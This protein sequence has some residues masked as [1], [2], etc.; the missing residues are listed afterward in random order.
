MDTK[1]C[2][3]CGKLFELERDKNNK[4]KQR[5]TCSNKCAKELNKIN[6][7]KQYSN[8][9]KQR[10]NNFIN[11]FNVKF[12]ERFEYVS[13]YVNCESIITCRCLMCGNIKTVG[14][15]CV[16]KNNTTVIVCENCKQIN[17][18]DKEEEKRLIHEENI[19]K[20]NEQRIVRA[21]ERWTKRLI[22][23]VKHCSQCGKLINN[24]ERDMRII[25][26]IFNEMEIRNITISELAA[27]LGVSKT[28]IYRWR[29]GIAKPKQIYIDTISDM[30]GQS[31]GKIT[32]DFRNEFCSIQCQKKY[33]NKK[34]ADHRRKTIKANGKVDWS[35][36]LKKLVKRDN[37]ICHICGHAVNMKSH[38]NSDFYGS[39]DHVIPLSKG[40]THSWDNVK[41]AHRKCNCEKR[42]NL[43]APSDVFS[44]CV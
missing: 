35:I 38:Y 1:E 5:K 7:M 22:S 34:H 23:L 17:L 14:A 27:R 11:K 20:L 41:L 16:R 39:I 3:V 28:S 19:Q 29:E 30:L 43:I 42:D 37:N 32:N 4:L 15:Q 36:T 33:S 9:I 6:R 26:I 24:H 44:A 12:A 31:L 21:K 10:E 2:I 25:N 18:K 13:D 40:G 8:D